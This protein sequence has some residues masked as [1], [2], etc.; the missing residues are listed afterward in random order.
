MN[1]ID[2]QINTYIHHTFNKSINKTIKQS[3]FNQS[4][5]K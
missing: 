4:M 2:K 5:N 3:I 1:K